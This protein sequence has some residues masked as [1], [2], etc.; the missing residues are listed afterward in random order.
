MENFQ[1]IAGPCSVESENQIIEIAKA[2]KKAGA[3]YL[4]GSAFKL[5]THAGDFQG[6][7]KEALI[8]LA[9]AKKETGLKTV[10]EIS[11]IRLIDLYEDVDV[12]QV[13]ERSMQNTDLLKELGKINKPIILKRGRS[14]TVEELLASAEY[15]LNGGNTN[16]ILC[17]RGI[18]TFENATRN[19]MD[20]SAIPLL[21]SMT[22]LNV[23]ADPSHATGRSDLVEA[24]SLAC[25]AAGANGLLIEVHNDP[26]HA[27]SDAKQAITPEEFSVLMT[28]VL[29]IR[30]AIK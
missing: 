8:F 16:I 15:I 7:G 1:V 9:N 2:V 25:V 29:K 14:A 20:V 26:P 12:L 27:L 19:T 21:H 17:E 22:N 5:R 10:S 23:I 13:G 18:R 24:M 3:T 30:E 11:D 6:L 4:R 28:K